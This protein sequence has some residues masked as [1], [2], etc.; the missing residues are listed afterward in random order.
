M[1]YRNRKGGIEHFSVKTKPRQDNEI[2]TE[3]CDVL[4]LC[5]GMKTMCCYTAEKVKA[6]VIVEAANGAVTPSAHQILLGH[7]KLILPDILISGGFA[8]AGYYEY[9]KNCQLVSK[10]TNRRLVN[11]SLGGNLFL[12]L[13]FSITKD[14]FKDLLQNAERNAKARIA[15]QNTISDD[16]DCFNESK[17]VFDAMEYIIGQISRVRS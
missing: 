2:L 11:I 1:D 12:F 16:V 17:L 13:F 7:R 6:K 5:A 9:L 15:G 14:M 3:D 10:V 4:V 8:L